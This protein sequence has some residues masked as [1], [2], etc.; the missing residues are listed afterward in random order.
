MLL[1]GGRFTS[2]PTRRRP[3]TTI[4]DLTETLRASVEA[5]KKTRGETRRRARD[6]EEKPTRLSQPGR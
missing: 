3:G 4:A 1:R 5:A 2:P 6:S